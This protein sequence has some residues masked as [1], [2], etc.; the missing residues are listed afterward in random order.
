MGRTRP[1][2]PRPARR[3]PLD[4]RVVPHTVRLRPE[5]SDAICR[6]ALREDRSV[7]AVLA[8][9]VTTYVDNTARLSRLRSARLDP[10]LRALRTSS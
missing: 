8:T 7:Y 3:V 10:V 2:R 5:I 6:M 9:I 1:F 4:Q